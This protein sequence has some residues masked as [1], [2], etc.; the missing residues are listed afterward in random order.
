MWHWD[1]F[2]V[3]IIKREKTMSLHIGAKEGQVAEKVL[4]PGDPLRAKYIAEH[5]LEHSI[6]YTT[7][8]GMFGFTGMYQ[9]KRVSVQGTGMGIPSVSIYGNELLQ[10]YGAKRLIRIGTCG[11]MRKELGIREIL[12]ANGAATDSAVNH[13]R[14][15]SI[16]FAPVPDFSLLFSAYT[17]GMKLKMPIHVG[18]VFTS[19]QFYDDRLKEKTELLASYGVLACDMETAE[20][21][22]LAAKYQA[23]ALT[24]LTVSDSL[25]TGENVP[26]KE[27]ETT[28]S[29][30]IRLA[31]E[32]V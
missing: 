19:D 21:Y 27:R 16:S 14:F 31:L 32:I 2:F 17:E 18:Q 26:P 24:I 15:G 8:R 4:L 20:L 30:M 6:C 25:L 12:L 10:A 22:T 29:D 28:F 1:G 13:E 23:Q 3:M 5:F 9:G 11:S 7:I